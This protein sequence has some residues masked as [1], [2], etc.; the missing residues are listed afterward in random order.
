MYLVN[1]ST[2]DRYS[3]YM[4]IYVYDIDKGMREE[5]Y[6][7]NFIRRQVTKANECARV[8]YTLLK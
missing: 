5:E 2:N 4:P 8:G 6:M 1:R 7:H 3:K